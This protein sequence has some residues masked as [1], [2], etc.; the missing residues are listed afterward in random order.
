MAKKTNPNKI[1]RTQADVDRAHQQ[2]LDFG[3]KAA[4]A[5][6]FQVLMD[7]EHADLEVMQRV[8]KEVC[9]LSQEIV[10]GAVTVADIKTVLRE[11]YN[12]FID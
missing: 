11:E 2:G 10:D 5:I 9:D 3:R 7:K 6:F 8:W 12:I 1:P 4:M